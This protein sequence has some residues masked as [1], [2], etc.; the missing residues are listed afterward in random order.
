MIHYSIEITFIGLKHGIVLR[1][2]NSE[3][4][5]EEKGEEDQLYYYNSSLME[6]IG[7]CLNELLKEMKSLSMAVLLYCLEHMSSVLTKESHLQEEPSHL[8]DST[9]TSSQVLLQWEEEQQTSSD[10]SFTNTL[11]LYLLASLCESMN[12]HLQDTLT[13][14]TTT[15][16]VVSSLLHSLAIIIRAHAKWCSKGE[17]VVSRVAAGRKEESL[18]GGHVTLSIGFGLLSAI[19][20]MK[21]VSV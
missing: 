13:K 20:T 17:V 8:D 21:E 2:V 19:L 12:D 4:I 14:S 6:D 10:V 9:N 18:T 11:I 5:V 1:V 15:I 3:L 7:W 16:V